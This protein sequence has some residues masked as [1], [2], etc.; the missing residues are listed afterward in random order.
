MYWD[1]HEQYLWLAFK[2]DV[3]E[4]VTRCLTCQQVKA[5]HQVLSRLLQPIQ[6]PQWK[7]ECVTMDFVSG[8]LLTPSKKDS[9][10]VIMDRLTQ[11]AHFIP[12][13][14][15]YSL[16][17]LA[18][19]YISKIVRLHEVS[20]SIISDRDLYL[21]SQFWKKLH[22]TLGT[23]LNISTTFCPQSD[24]QFERAIQVLEDMLR[25]CVINFRGSWEER[26]QL[27]KFTYNNSFNR[28][29]RCFHI[30]LFMVTNVGHFYVGLNWEKIKFWG[31]I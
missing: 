22:E 14:I 5:E 11:S 19:L 15:D 30:M 17:K 24:E 26:F 21:M 28:A 7:W 16:Q 25:G 12:V 3:T 1:I 27:A 9:V 8:L 23:R 18:K 13:H 2:H 10:W 4:F 31:Q 20:I 6:I 29:F